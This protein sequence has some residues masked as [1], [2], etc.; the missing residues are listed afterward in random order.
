VLPFLEK[1]YVLD[2]GV[3]VEF[4]VISVGLELVGL[5]LLGR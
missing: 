2:P 4:G 5:E 3:V 1:K